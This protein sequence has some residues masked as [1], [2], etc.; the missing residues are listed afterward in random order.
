MSWLGALSGSPRL[1]SSKFTEKTDASALSGRAGKT[2]WGGQEAGRDAWTVTV[3]LRVDLR[4]RGQG[5][6][7]RSKLPPGETGVCVAKAGEAAMLVDRG[8]SAGEDNRG[9]GKGEGPG[10]VGGAASRP[11]RHDGAAVCPASN[12]RDPS[13]HSCPRLNP[14]TTRRKPVSFRHKVSLSFS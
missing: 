1:I 5:T 11:R 4:P 6:D 13:P 3:G 14:F 7:D 9:D 10:V 12:R 2:H 8:V